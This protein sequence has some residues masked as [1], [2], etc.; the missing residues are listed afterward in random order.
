MYPYLYQDQAYARPPPHRAGG[1]GRRRAHAAP[2]PRGRHPSS[3]TASTKMATYD[4]SD[5]DVLLLGFDSYS[6]KLIGD[7]AVES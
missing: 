2:Y 3:T 7:D 6:G 1:P 5:R 4:G